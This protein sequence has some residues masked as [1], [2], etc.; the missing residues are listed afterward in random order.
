[1]MPNK[2]KNSIKSDGCLYQLKKHPDEIIFNLLKK[3][4]EDGC[5][6]SS[7][8]WEL[9]ENGKIEYNFIIL[10][11]NSYYK[12]TFYSNQ[13]NEGF[14]LKTSEVNKCEEKCLFAT[15]S[16]QDKLTYIQFLNYIVGGA[17]EIVCLE[18]IRI[19]HPSTHRDH[20]SPFASFDF[21]MTKKGNKAFLFLDYFG[22]NKLT[23]DKNCWVHFFEKL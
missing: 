19:Y 8:K 17:G 1:M 12:K 15:K 4:A 18:S 11:N 10:K 6:K 20:R 5:V 22:K 9:L 16:M 14:L 7:E 3:K 13:E 2:T 23:I 21:S